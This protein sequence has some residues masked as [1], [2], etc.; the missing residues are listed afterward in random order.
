MTISN[1]YF[2][3]W[4]NGFIFVKINVKIARTPWQR[5][6]RCWSQ[7]CCRERP[8]G[9]PRHESREITIV[10]K[11]LWWWSFSH[12]HRRTFVSVSAHLFFCPNYKAQGQ[13]WR[14]INVTLHWQPLSKLFD[15]FIDFVICMRFI[16]SSCCLLW[17]VWLSG[18]L[19]PTQ[20]Q[21]SKIVYKHSHLWATA[22]RMAVSAKIWKIWPN[23][24]SFPTS[25][26]LNRIN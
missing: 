15:I 9:E 4:Q 23:R 2:Q 7:R 16:F 21:L 26:V 1:I 22:S 24:F 12:V 20:H 14:R 8:W 19:G 25:W 11:S 18:W 5:R 17:T 6:S 3:I 10:I 13:D